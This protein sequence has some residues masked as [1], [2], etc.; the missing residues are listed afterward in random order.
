MAT[1]V[2]FQS[3]NTSGTAN[4]QRLVEDL[5]IESLKI[6]GHDVHYMPRTL[7]NRDTIFDEDELSKFTQQ[8][9]LEMYMENVEGYEGEGELFTRF[10]IEIRDQ[11]TFVLSKRR[12]EQMVDREE[13]AGGT[14]QLTARPAEGDLLYFPKTKSLFEIKLVEFQ[15][16]FYQLG[17]I[18]TFRLQCELFE[19]SSERL[20]TGDT[21]IDGI[22]DL[23]SLDILQFQ[24]QLENG[25]LLRLE[26]QSSLI[27][28]SFQTSRGNVGVDNEDF[29][30]WQ[31]A[32]NILDFTEKNPFGEI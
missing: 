11:A 26:D 6:Y 9:P 22:E 2:Y 31:T 29:D 3:G 8:Y 24:F 16:P 20:D 10:G 23:Q 28:E 15:N 19:Y 7:V 27:L 32:S 17:K 30:S 25:D 13:D 14:F 18:Y 4:E 1:N 21:D 12:W 5:V